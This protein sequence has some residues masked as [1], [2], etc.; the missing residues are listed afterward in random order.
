MQF[1]F[2]KSAGKLFRNQRDLLKVISERRKQLDELKADSIRKSMFGNVT[3]LLEKAKQDIIE[4]QIQKE[5]E[6]SIASTIVETAV[7]KDN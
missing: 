4:V 6:K 5:E 2:P 3:N 7:A 1:E